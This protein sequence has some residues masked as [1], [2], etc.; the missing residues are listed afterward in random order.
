MT[1]QGPK[2]NLWYLAVIGAAVLA[3]VI[4][5]EIIRPDDDPLSWVIRSAALLGYFCVFAA[6]ASSAYMRRM[7]QFFGK[8]FLK[9]HHIVSITGLALITIHPL[10]VAW[11]ALSLRV[12]I[13]DVSSWYRF[14]LL[15]GR[16]SWFL[17]VIAALV[18]VLRKPIGKNWKWLHYLNYLAFWLAT[19][20]G[21]L[22]GSNVQNM[23][24]RV[25]FVVLGLIVLGVMVKKRFLSRIN[26][27]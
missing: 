13:P 11:R 16:P 26:R 21:I 18:A 1:K 20:H 5:F 12:F 7:T 24:M 4:V 10:G 19:A 8:P 14:L 23:P 2:G 27:N 15:G 17:I 9:V 6:I 25:L 3:L 22:I